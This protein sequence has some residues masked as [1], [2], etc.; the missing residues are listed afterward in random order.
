MNTIIVTF[1]GF[2]LVLCMIYAVRNEFVK[3][4]F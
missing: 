1:N 2:E 3:I 4:K